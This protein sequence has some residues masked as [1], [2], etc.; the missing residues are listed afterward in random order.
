MQCIVVQGLPVIHTVQQINKC[1]IFIYI[2]WRAQASGG[3]GVKW[4]YKGTI[5]DPGV[6][7]WIGLGDEF[8]PP[9]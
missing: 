4:R 8:G 3:A 7:G 6:G 5:A 9:R 2:Q 1:S